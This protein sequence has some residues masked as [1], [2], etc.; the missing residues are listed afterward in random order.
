M[1]SPYLIRNVTSEQYHELYTKRRAVFELLK[2]NLR[3]KHYYFSEDEFNELCEKNKNKTQ[4]YFNYHG[5]KYTFKYSP[6]DEVI[7]FFIK[8]NGIEFY[9]KND[10]LLSTR[11]Q[12][13]FEQLVDIVKQGISLCELADDYFPEDLET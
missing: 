7:G 9:V 11:E 13:V 10:V 1:S 6:N 2:I 8:R 5:S 12:R 3:Q 4:G